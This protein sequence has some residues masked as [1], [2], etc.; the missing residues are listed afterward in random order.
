MTMAMMY[1]RNMPV[2]VN[3]SFVQVRM[4]VRLAAV[5]GGI[6]LVPMMFVMHMFMRM[7]HRIMGMNMCMTLCQMQPDA[8]PHQHAR[9]PEP[10]ARR[11][12]EQEQRHCGADERCGGK[13][14]A[15]PG[16]AELLQGQHKKHEAQAVAAKPDQP[17]Q[18][19]RASVR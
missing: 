18:R 16:G 10:C 12:A 13:V 5:P 2:T 15:G 9:R 7:R 6:M 8:R 4:G 1:V 3:L 17:C 19:R 14:G 11:F